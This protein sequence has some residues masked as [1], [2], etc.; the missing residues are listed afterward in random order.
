MVLVTA[1]VLTPS[2]AGGP[3]GS[4]EKNHVILT[5]LDGKDPYYGAVKAYRKLHSDAKILEFE[6]RDVK[7]VARKL[8][9]L[10]PRFVSVVIKPEDLDFNFQASMLELCTS[11]DDDP[12]CDFSFGYITGGT[13]DEAVA[14][15][16]NIARARKG[17]LPRKVLNSPVSSSNTRIEGDAR[18]TYGLDWPLTTLRY[19]AAHG[20]ETDHK[21]IRACSPRA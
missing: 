3:V 4:I 2:A 20:K 14:F 15:V 7:G 17:G 10:E 16:K 12:F 18:M 21:E 19:G 6:G 11:L 1:L 5:N 13:A 8:T 9:D